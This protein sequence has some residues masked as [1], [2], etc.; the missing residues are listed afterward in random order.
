[1]RPLPQIIREFANDELFMEIKAE[2]DQY[3]KPLAPEL[4]PG[5]GKEIYCWRNPG[6]ELVESSKK[7]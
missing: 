7:R 1:V 6:Y 5:V 4:N 3:V 2:A